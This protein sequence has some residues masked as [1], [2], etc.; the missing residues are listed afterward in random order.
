[1][2]NWGQ[3]ESGHFTMAITGKFRSRI[4]QAITGSYM[5]A[6][7][8]FPAI[9]GLEDRLIQSYI[10]VLTS[11]RQK[12]WQERALPDFLI[13]GGMKCGTSSLYNYLNQHP[14][15]F[16]SN[17]KEI[18]YFSHDE[19][20]ERGES[21]YRAHFPKAKKLPP[22]SLVFE[23]SPDYLFRP[24]AAQRMASLLP[25]IKLI[26]LLRN[27]TERAISHYFH[28]VKKA[29]KPGDVLSAI[30]HER[31]KYRPKGMYKNQLEKYYNQFDADN[32]LIINSEEF[33]EDPSRTLK[34]VY[35]FLGVDADVEIG[36]LSPKQVGF[37]REPVDAAVY[38][39]LNDYYKPHNEAL[40]RL[41]GKEFDW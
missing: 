16:R 33:F 34:Q 27:P 40:F 12:R 24:K 13:I 39:Y 6:M 2:G 14:R 1:M 21:W 7:N 25:D 38:D 17:Y 28:D 19:F 8:R 18:R 9:R 10:D 30:Q 15:L 22:G 37:N 35:K 11:Q 41:I 20:Y 4:E 3:S 32:I 29:R 31:T 23:A 36:D 5:R 26:A